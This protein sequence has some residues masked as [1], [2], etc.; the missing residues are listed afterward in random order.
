MGL[1]GFAQVDMHVDEPGRDDRAARID[2]LGI[3]RVQV[4]ADLRDQAIAQEN[5]PHGV[6]VLRGVDDAATADEQRNHAVVRSLRTGKT[7]AR[8][9]LVR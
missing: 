2:D 8:S 6:E 1:A 9:V 3:A 5:V 7:R 4:L